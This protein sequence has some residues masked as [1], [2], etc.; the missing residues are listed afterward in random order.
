MEPIKSTSKAYWKPLGTTSKLVKFSKK[1]KSYENYEERIILWKQ[2][3]SINN[4]TTNWI[5]YCVK[6]V[7]IRSF[8]WS[9]FNSIRA[10]C[11]KIRTRKNSVFGHFSRSGMEET[12]YFFDH[13]ILNLKNVCNGGTSWTI[14]LLDAFERFFDFSLTLIRYGF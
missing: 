1:Q 8:F 14:L 3:P 5:V 12:S 7:Q 4:I 9:V 2:E 11:G 10:E 6:S 13:L